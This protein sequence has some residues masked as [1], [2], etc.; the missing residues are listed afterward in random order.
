MAGGCPADLYDCGER[1]SNPEELREAILE[2]LR[3]VIDPET[4]VDVVRMRLIEDLTVD[5]NGHVAYR[6]RPSSPLCPIAIPLSLAI[7]LAIDEVE[8]VTGQ[9]LE[10]I[11]YIQAEKLTELLRQLVFDEI[12]SDQ[13]SESGGKD[14]KNSCNP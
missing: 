13:A 9:D 2:K 10:V 7:K 3:Q 1:M 14:G 12:S 11:G 5:K 8:G 6:F 4:G